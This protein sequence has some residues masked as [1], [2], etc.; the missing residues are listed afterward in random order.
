MQDGPRVIRQPPSVFLNVA[1]GPVQV[2][3]A[4][5]ECEGVVSLSPARA[6]VPRPAPA[7]DGHWRLLRAATAG[8]LQ[9]APG[10]GLGLPRR[11]HWRQ[12][13]VL[14]EADAPP[15]APAGHVTSGAG[16]H[17][18]GVR[19]TARGQ[20]VPGTGGGR[21]LPGAAPVS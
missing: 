3:A 20:P 11:R 4:D 8:V 16:R 18:V 13:R 10:V 5:S 1:P 12:V 6:G 14:A 17:R 9:D 2:L 19:L 7:Q 21:G 15:V